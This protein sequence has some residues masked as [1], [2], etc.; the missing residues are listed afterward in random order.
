M[1]GEQPRQIGPTG[2]SLLFY[3]NHVKP[4]ISVNQKYFPFYLTQ[5][6]AHLSPSRPGQKGVGRR[7]GRWA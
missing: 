6:S 7:H 3:G 5:I 1:W 2:K 4:K